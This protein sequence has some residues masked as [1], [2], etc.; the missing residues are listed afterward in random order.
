MACSTKKEKSSAS[1][2]KKC[3]SFHY[4]CMQTRRPRTKVSMKNWCCFL[5]TSVYFFLLVH[6]IPSSTRSRK[7]SESVRNQESEAILSLSSASS[8]TYARNPTSTSSNLAS[9]VFFDRELWSTQEIFATYCRAL[10]PGLAREPVRA[11]VSDDRI[12]PRYARPSAK[13]IPVYVMSYNNPTYVHAMVRFLRCYEAS[14]TIVDNAS[15]LPEH[16]R[17]LSALESFVRVRRHDKNKGAHSFFTIPNIVS[18]PK[19]F[20]VTDADLRP[21]PDLPPLFLETLAN[22]TQLFPGRKAGFALDVCRS[23]NFM[24][25]TYFKGKNIAEW[26]SQWWK[27]PVSSTKSEGRGRKGESRLLLNSAD[28]VMLAGIDT[29]FAV[30]DRDALLRAENCTA[31]YCFDYAGVRVGASFMASHIPWLCYFPELLDEGEYRSYYEEAGRKP[32]NEGS[33]MAVMLQQGEGAK[34]LPGADGVK[35][36]KNMPAAQSSLR[37]NFCQ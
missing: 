5:W 2:A 13:K 9:P 11:L 31:T 3:A 22:L 35:R 14:V 25:G 24:K 33:T 32:A 26:E 6:G 15:T 30:Y 18:A 20:A 7:G 16:L 10:H 29:T 8:S 17:L 4:F 27:E 34:S 19:Y 28:P 36:R 37:T 23:A 21:D 1:R 12:T